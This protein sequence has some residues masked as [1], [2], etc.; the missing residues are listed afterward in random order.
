MLHWYNTLVADG[1]YPQLLRGGAI[2]A[3]QKY[4]PPA[5]ATLLAAYQHVQLQAHREQAVN[6]RLRRWLVL[7]VAAGAAA[8]LLAVLVLTAALPVA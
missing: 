5:A 1:R 4:V 7:A 3:D 8:V 6:Q 2:A